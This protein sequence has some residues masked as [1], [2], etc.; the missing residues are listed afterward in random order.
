MKTRLAVAAAVVMALVLLGAGYVVHVLRSVDA[1]AFRRMVLDR[2]S[3]VAGT[4]IQAR[5]VDISVWRGVTLQGVKVA[6]PPPFPGDLLTAD[7]F[8]L[9]YNLWTLLR[10]RVELSRLSLDKPTLTLAMD[11]RGFFN[12][13]RL[14]GTRAP[15]TQGASG[16]PVAVAL[17][18]LSVDGARIIVRDP[19]AAFVRVEGAALD[20]S[21]DLAGTSIDGKG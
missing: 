6:N 17:S 7:S 18:M 1:P 10:G 4:K 14:G 8:V 3:A 19:R 2:A 11:S 20:S 12:Y 16:L 13:E 9:R 21:L 15:A 5:S